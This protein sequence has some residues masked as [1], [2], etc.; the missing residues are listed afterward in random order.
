[1]ALRAA[2]AAQVDWL[3]VDVWWHHG[4]IVARHDAALWRLP[5]TYGRKRIGLMPLR[6]ITL[7]E[8]LDAVDGTDI[9][10]LL[11]LKGIAAALPGALAE[12]LRRRDALGRAALCGQEWGP[13]DAAREVEPGVAV[14]FSL[15]REEHYPAY[16][17]RLEDGS[18]PPRISIRHTLLTPER[19][20]ELHQRGVTMFSWTVNDSARA[21][22]L[23]D[24]GVDGI[25]SDSLSVLAGL[26]P[27]A[28]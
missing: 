21:Q 8:L 18:A 3:E 5:V 12:G 13:L 28:R 20:N 27:A 14:F 7:D 19:V 17:R 25:I 6:P 2:L 1:M 4:R 26:R 11:D 23:V 10:L 24:W 22:T 9:R 15:G 16:L